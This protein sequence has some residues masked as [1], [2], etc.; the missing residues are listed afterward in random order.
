MSLDAFL[1]RLGRTLSGGML[2]RL[3]I[4]TALLNRPQIL[5]LDEPTVGLDPTARRSSGNGSKSCARGRNDAARH[6]APDGGSGAPVRP[7]RDHGPRRARR[8]GNAGGALRRSSPSPRSTTSSP[9]PPAGRSRKEGASEMSREAAASR[10]GSA[11]LDRAVL[12]ERHR[13]DGLGG[14]PQAPPRQPRHR[15]AL[16][17]AAALA[18]HLRHGAAAQPRARRRLPRL[19]RVP[20]ARGDGA[21]G[22][23]HRHLLRPRRHLGARRRP[24]AAPARHADPPAR[25]RARQGD[26]APGSARSP[27]RSCCSPCS[28][29][30]ASRSTGTPAKI[31]GALVLLVLAT[32]GVRVPLDDPRLARAHARALHGHRPARDDAALLRLERALPALDHAALAADPRAR[33]T[34]SRTR[35]TACASCCSASRAAERSG[36]TSSF[37]ALFLVADGDDRGEDVPARDSLT[38]PEM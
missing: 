3:E 12:G 14:A 37:V 35:C 5:F 15:H 22:A 17:A 10:A 6:D 19:P 34:R 21:G 28:R 30:P 1:D 16:G 13:R 31:V 32:G 36:S 8:A 4:A 11:E 2:R 9:P 26:A 7:H 38:Q 20:R 25:D 33:A 18:V 29:S 24:A 23:L 27:R